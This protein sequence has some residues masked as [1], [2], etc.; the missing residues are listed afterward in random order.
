MDREPTYGATFVRHLAKIGRQTPY[1]YED[2]QLVKAMSQTELADWIK[3]ECPEF[4]EV[5]SDNPA[6]VAAAMICGA[7]GGAEGRKRGFIAEWDGRATR[8]WRNA[9]PRAAAAAPHLLVRALAAAQRHG[10]GAAAQRDALALGAA[11]NDE[12]LADQAVRAQRV[13]RRHAAPKALG[14]GH[15][16]RR[17]PPRAARPARVARHA[18]RVVRA[19]RVPHHRGRHQH[20]GLGDSRHGARQRFRRRVWRRGSAHDGGAN[21]NF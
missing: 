5:I 8:R 10:G 14:E 7:R 17:L 12:R 11:R 6:D 3:A 19:Q 2:L 15:A 18:L 20:H 13:R 9:P 4:S 16:A 21:S 1:R